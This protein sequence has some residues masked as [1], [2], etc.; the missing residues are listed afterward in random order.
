MSFALL[1]SAPWGFNEVN[2]TASLVL[3]NTFFLSFFPFFF[4]K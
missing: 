3:S 2:R 4:F 1:F